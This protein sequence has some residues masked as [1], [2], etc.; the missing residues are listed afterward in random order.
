MSQGSRN[1]ALRHWMRDQGVQL[2]A[3]TAHLLQRHQKLRVLGDGCHLRC[4]Q[5]CF[6]CAAMLT[7]AT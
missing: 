3:R 5:A 2:A 7:A 1:A 6:Q 4:L